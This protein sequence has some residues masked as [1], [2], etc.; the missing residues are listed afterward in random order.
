MDAWTGTLKNP[1]KCLCRWEPDRWSNFFIPLAHLCAVTYMAEISLNVTLN[2]QIQLLKYGG[3]HQKK[4]TNL[5]HAYV[6]KRWSFR[7]IIHH[8][9]C[10]YHIPRGVFNN[11]LYQVYGILVTT[12]GTRVKRSRKGKADLDKCVTGK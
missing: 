1:R 4:K 10:R 2:I 8:Q 12:M 11:L 7:K 3:L 5:I 9:E 6:I